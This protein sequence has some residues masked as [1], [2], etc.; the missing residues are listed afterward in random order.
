MSQDDIH[1]AYHTGT[2]LSLLPY[3][4]RVITHT[5]QVPSY[6]SY[7]T[8][9]ELSLQL[10][11]SYRLAQPNESINRRGLLVLLEN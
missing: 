9:T 6:H 10:T 2:E 7:H 8:S 4:H 5:I 3:R 11:S 1:V